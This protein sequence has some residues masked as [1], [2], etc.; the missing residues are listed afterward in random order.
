MIGRTNTGGGGGGL[1]FKIIAYAT[2]TAL[3][4]DIPAENTIGVVTTNKVTAWAVSVKQPES[5]LNGGV[6]ISNGADSPVAFN[7][8]KSKKNAIMVYP[9]CAMQYVNGSWLMLKAKS[10]RNGEWV[11]WWD[12]TVIDGNNQCA[13]IVGEWVEVL[14]TA[15]KVTWADEGVTLTY[16]GNSGRH[17]SIYSKNP[18]D[19]TSYKTLRATV[20]KAVGS[21]GGNLIGVR[22]EPT[23]SKS[24][25]DYAPGYD[26]YATVNASTNEQI[27]NIDVSNLSGEYYVQIGCGVTTLTIKRL[28]FI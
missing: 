27:I 16:S 28:Q 22:K 6:W 11:D 13:E 23:T 24:I 1:N 20:T 3:L 7:A 19:I 17:A 8:L 2:E 4:A 18:V 9:L 15:G 25:N 26:A 21:A 14:G 12:G 10:F 5:M